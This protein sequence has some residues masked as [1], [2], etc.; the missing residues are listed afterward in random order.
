MDK[1]RELQSEHPAQVRFLIIKAELLCRFP[2]P[3]SQ[4][5]AAACSHLEGFL[6]CVCH[7]KDW[8]WSQGSHLPLILWMPRLKHPQNS[9]KVHLHWHHGALPSSHHFQSLCVPFSRDDPKTR[10]W[11][12]RPQGAKSSG[13]M[14]ERDLCINKKANE[15][16][17]L[18]R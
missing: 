5:S 2:V 9:L 4:F 14:R 18:S 12:I 7:R 6:C 16:I 10:S 1:S 11:A 15:K 8:T 13:N 17:N 3:S